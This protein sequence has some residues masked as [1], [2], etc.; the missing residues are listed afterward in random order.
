MVSTADPSHMSP[1]RV[2]PSVA[3]TRRVH[4][5]H[6]PQSVAVSLASR[7]IVKNAVR[8]W[9]LTPNLHWPLEYV[10]SFAGLVPRLGS[11]G[12]THPVRLEHCAAEWVRAPGVSGER[13]ILY[14]HG[15]AFLTCGLNTH[16]PMVT[17]LSKAADAAVLAVAYR[18]L[19][20]HQITDA[21]DDGL[22]GLRWL[23]DRG[24]DGDRV[25]VA[26]DSAGGYLAFMTTL[27]AI[28]N[29]VMEPAGI[30][31]VSPFTDTDPARKL[32][33]RN[34]RKCSMFTCRAFSR[35]AEYLSNAQV[36]EGHGDSTVAS[37]VDADLSSLPPVTIHASSDEL[38]VADAEL[39]AKRLE[40]SGIH[41]DL[42]LWDGQI[43]DFP[44]AADVLPEGRRAI[45]YL[46][47]FV[48]DVTAAG[49]RFSNVRR[50]RTAAAG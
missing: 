39:M 26:G 48:K 25:V 38:L 45:K 12:T 22:D 18:K 29:E 19:P 6:S 23:Q 14:L 17:R 42:H 5:R 27:L 11:A 47:D 50:L 8:A 31:T 34:A 2:L 43:H 35:F 30:A 49:T 28:Q 33:H 13:A 4:H 3:T 10:D 46:G 20:A 7:L 16:R 32:K 21:I 1:R 40:A 44:L 9:A 36:L 15:G 37:P 41:C 24:F